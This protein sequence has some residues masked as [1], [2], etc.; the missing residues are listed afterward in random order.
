MLRFLIDLMEEKPFS[1]DILQNEMYAKFVKSVPGET[2][3]RK[4]SFFSYLRAAAANAKGVKDVS[5]EKIEDELLLRE[6]DDMTDIK[7]EKESS[8][9]D[10]IR[11]T[12]REN[13][14]RMIANGKLSDEDIAE[15]SGL[16][17]EDVI[18]LRSQA[19]A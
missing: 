11:D 3:R 7:Y 1:D 15:C 8:Y 17:V 12:Q 10:G 4:T 14:K 5:L 6:V 18:V 16:S 13:A 2:S 9:L 19:E